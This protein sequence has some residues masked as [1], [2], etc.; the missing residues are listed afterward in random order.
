LEGRKGRQPDG[1]AKTRMVY[2]GCVFTQ[3]RRDQ[4]GS[5][6]RDHDST[7]Y[8]ASFE[9]AEDFGIRLRR[10]ARRRGSGT[11]K[12]VVVLMDGAAALEK[13]GSIN[14]P[15]CQRI[16]D[17]YHACEHLGHVLEAIWGK[18]YKAHPGL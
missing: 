1:S 2:L 7:S 18:D 5:P 11:A 10:E 16:V 15:G 17:F 13:L 4:D 12:E 8:L 14:F 9:C 6:L 3:H